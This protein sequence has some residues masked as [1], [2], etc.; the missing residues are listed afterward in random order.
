MEYFLKFVQKEADPRNSALRSRDF[1]GFLTYMAMFANANGPAPSQDLALP[2]PNYFCNS[3]HNTYL[4]GNQL[5]SEASSDIYK[6]VLERGCRCLEIDV[7]DGQDD[8]DSRRSSV[9]S[10]SSDDSHT[11]SIMAKRVHDAREAETQ[12]AGGLKREMKAEARG[13]ISSISGGIHKISSKAKK[14]LP[15][16]SADGD[17][18]TYAAQSNASQTS[19]R[20]DS[21]DH[22]SHCICETIRDNAF[23]TSD[24]PVV[25]SLEVHAHHEQQRMMVQ[26]MAEVWKDYLVSVP[27]STR[28]A[29]SRGDPIELP[30]PEQLR[31]KILIKVKSSQVP[32]EDRALASNADPVDGEVL[33]LRPCDS[34]SST[35]IDRSILGDKGGK[36]VPTPKIIEEL[37]ALGI[38]TTAYSF[39]GLDKSEA[40]LPQHV[41]SLSEP[42]LLDY[43]KKDRKAVFE[44][45]RNFLMRSYPSQ[46]RVR[47]S[48][49][50][51]SFSWRQGVQFAAL[52]W[53]NTDL[54][55]MLNHAMFDGTGGWVLK[56]EPY[57]SD[58]WRAQ[59]GPSSTTTAGAARQGNALSLSIDI[60][61]GQNLPLCP[62]ETNSKKYHPYVSCQLHVEKPKDS[63]QAGQSDS[64]SDEDSS[65]TWKRKTSSSTG[66][67][68]DFD[69]Q[70]LQFPR[71]SQVLQELTFVRFKVK[72]QGMSG[73]RLVHL[74]DTKGRQTEG[75]LLVG[76][77][78]QLT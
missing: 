72:D 23:T 17:S 67:H 22:P 35:S 47:S 34:T 2:L 12:I 44:H 5:Y 65:E 37:S 24:L 40:R 43:F 52:N 15:E 8:S 6:T 4:T 32:E 55:M 21:H 27:E 41:F 46:L 70:R 50:D 48:N 3:S 60:Y 64:D 59:Q 30:S 76:V 63:S 69:G 11:D 49:P 61:A 54:G 58:R 31:R 9:S 42:K 75:V 57:R 53:Q 56:P 18:A 13:M 20:M 51:P 39:K 25:V 66:T 62:G 38:Y 73:Y 78:K 33:E 10:S 1:T 36:R 68:P 74:L 29:L 71:C 16:V 77:T 26:I 45:N 28:E 19:L 14:M 7:W